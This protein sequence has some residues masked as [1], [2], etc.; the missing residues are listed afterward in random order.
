MHTCTT[1]QHPAT[2]CNTLHHAA[3]HCNTLQHT[4][5]AGRAMC[6]CLS[7]RVRENIRDCERN[8]EHQRVCESVRECGRV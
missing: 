6:V 4:A 1:L 2:H 8:S 7:A 5:Y 3:S